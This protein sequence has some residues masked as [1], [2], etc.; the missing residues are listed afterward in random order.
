MLMLLFCRADLRA[1][2]ICFSTELRFQSSAALR[3]SGSVRSYSGRK[4]LK[5]VVLGDSLGLSG[6]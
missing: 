5:P 3:S 2:E 1:A 6:D 4:D